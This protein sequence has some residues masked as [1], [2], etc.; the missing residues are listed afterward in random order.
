MTKREELDWQRQ[1]VEKFRDSGCYA[2]KTS[3]QFSAGF[4][5]LM[6]LSRE[7]LGAR[8][9]EVKVLTFAQHAYMTGK[10]WQRKVDLTP[11]QQIEMARIR[12]AWG[13]V[14]LLLI[15][16]AEDASADKSRLGLLQV[17]LAESLEP[18]EVVA[19]HESTRRFITWADLKKP[20]N[21][22]PVGK[23]LA[24]HRFSSL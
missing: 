17:K 2:R 3:P 24:T 10:Q 14:D 7:H 18:V 22:H 9:Y 1:L 16:Q 4:P 20:S 12:A 11:R 23:L 8:F 5:D 13:L 21:W 6:V 15:L 19:T